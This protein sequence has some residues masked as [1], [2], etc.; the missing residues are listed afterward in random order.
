[1][2]FPLVQDDK[3]NFAFVLLEGFFPDGNLPPE[4][5]SGEGA[6]LDNQ[7]HVYRRRH[8]IERLILYREEGKVRRHFPGHRRSLGEIIEPGGLSLDRGGEK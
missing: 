6:E 7:G 3:L 4:G 2:G 5:G 1:V 8:E